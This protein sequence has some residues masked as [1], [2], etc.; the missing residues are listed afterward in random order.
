MSLSTTSTLSLSTSRNGD[1]TI[2]LGSL[3]QYFTTLS[4]KKFFLISNLNLPWHN[5][6]LFSLILSLLTRRWS[7]PPP[8]HNLL[9]GSCESYKVP[10]EPPLLQT[11]QSYIPQLHL[12]RC[13]LDPSSTSLPFS[14]HSSGPQCLSYSEGP[15]TEHSRG[16]HW[17]LVRGSHLHDLLVAP[18]LI[19]AR[20]SLAFLATW[21][22]CW[23]MFREKMSQKLYFYSLSQAFS[24][25]YSG[26]LVFA[27]L[28]K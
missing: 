13:A 11:K 9:P 6:R 7:R 26:I 19:Q 14:Q 28:R 16:E 25:S 24:C 8:C 12:I 4:E 23:L 20:M 1:S 21:A 22:H 5:L 17:T 18:F 2:S 27:Q 3:F 10:P 15:K